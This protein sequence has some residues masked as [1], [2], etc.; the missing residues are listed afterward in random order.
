MLQPLTWCPCFSRVPVFVLPP[1]PQDMSDTLMEWFD[2]AQTVFGCL[3]EIMI[4]A[5]IERTE[6]LHNM[7]KMAQDILWWPFT[8]HK[9][10]PE[11]AVTVIDSRC[12]EN[13]AVHKVH[14]LLCFGFSTISYL[15]CQNPNFPRLV[16]FSCANIFCFQYRCLITI[17]SRNSLM[18][19]QVGGHRGQIRVYRSFFSFFHNLQGI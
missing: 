17:S 11:E 14:I 10:V 6:R 16:I 9:L 1:I 12:G 15:D 13:F 19:V 5:H 2:K 18:L 7:P 8:Q 3:K 4:S